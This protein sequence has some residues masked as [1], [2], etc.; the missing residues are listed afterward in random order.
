MGRAE[1]ERIG[2]LGGTF[3]PVHVGHLV[4]AADARWQLSL[5][6]V[7]LM[8]ANQPWQKEGTRSISPAEDRYGMVAAAVADVP[9]VEASRMEI[10]RGGETYTA[11]TLEA[12]AAQDP[13]AELFCI[14]G[15]DVA[16]E[17]RSW[18]RVDDVLRLAT[19]VVVA[20]LGTG[21]SAPD[22]FLRVDIPRIDVSSSELRA[23]AAA[24]GP[25]DGLVPPAALH[26]IR[27][28]GLYA[29]GG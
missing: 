16:A 29:G 8:V 13:A 23:R 27:R 12:L 17:L 22:G 24:G 14:V 11:E 2:V 15:A 19:I 26:W 4:A 10:D 20:R 28:R 18:R 7:L 5:D 9:G 6:R 1:R 3:D 21:T 25:L